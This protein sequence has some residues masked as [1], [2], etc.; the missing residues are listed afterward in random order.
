MKSAAYG[1]RALPALLSVIVMP[2]STASDLT[3]ASWG[4]VYTESQQRAYGESWER[5]TGKT[6]RWVTYNG[7][8]GEVRAQVGSGDVEWDIVDVFAHEARVGCDDALFERLPG[9]AFLP[10][11][12]GTPLSEDLLVEIPNDCVVPN[13]IWSWVVFYDA[14]R[15]FGE[16]PR[17]L[18]DFFDLE[19]FP[20]RRGLGA[21][22]QANLELA[23]VA[24]GVDPDRVYEV[25]STPQGIERAFAK[26]D[27]I[28]DAVEFWSSGVEPLELVGSGEAIMST[29]Y[30]GRVG[31]AVLDQGRSFVTLRDLQVLDEEWF[32]MLRD[33]PNRELAL[34]FLVHASAT[35]QQ[36][37][38]ARWITYS[39]MRRSA[40]ALIEAGEPWHHTGAEI[41]PHLPGRGADS[42]GI[43]RVDSDWWAANGE[44][45]TQRF[46]DWMKHW[47]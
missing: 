47:Q 39:P 35:R 27:T 32:V 10:A 43:V 15:V 42:P 26:L 28:R 1:V 8:L 6:I 46:N 11:P 5:K 44:A 40:L 18:A 38:Q 17:E 24:D 12:D 25:L 31:A 4:G 3:I 23:L 29:A 7:G 2:L 14:D 22:P 13:I 41:L 37:E 33:T 9:D 20:G 45:V 21:F 36:A 30:N 19:R 16:A 34:G